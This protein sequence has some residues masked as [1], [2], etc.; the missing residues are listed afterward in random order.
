MN[1]LAGLGRGLI[2][3]FQ[4]TRV[5]GLL[6]FAAT[7]IGIA[8]VFYRY[9]EGWGWIDALYFSVVTISTVGYGDLSPQTTPGKLFTIGYIFVGLGIFVAAATTLANAILTHREKTI[10]DEPS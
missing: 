5:L 3:A 6:A 1:S 10:D 2:A 9:V 7:I 4:D 8:A